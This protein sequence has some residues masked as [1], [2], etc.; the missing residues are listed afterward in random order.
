METN[1]APITTESSQKGIPQIGIILCSDI[2]NEALPALK[3]LLLQ[4]NTLQSAFEYQIVPTGADIL[5]ETLASGIPLD[6]K[7]VLDE[8]PRF[9]A[10]YTR[11]LSHEIQRYGMSDDCP[12]H[13]IVVSRATFKDG[14]YMDGSGNISIL[15]LGN[16]E[17]SMAPPS[18]VEFVISMVL[19]SSIYALPSVLGLGHFATKGCLFDFNADLSNAR[20]MSLQGFICWECRNKL[21]GL[22]Y[23]ELADELQ[24]ILDK[25]W[26]G[27]VSECN[28]PAGI[29]AKLGYNLFLTKGLVPRWW[30]RWLGAIE[31]EGIKEVIRF[32]GA[33]LLAGSLIY[34]GLKK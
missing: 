30:E 25:K 28:S 16:W 26:I 13:Y 7:A 2:A 3:Y 34:F 20:F 23:P 12:N 11:S 24:V 8:L 1:T 29:A 27:D 14:Y 17:R 4:L 18:L 33:V 6:R 15:A 10:E 31:Q 19:S 32:I 5:L 21:K 22:G 9:S